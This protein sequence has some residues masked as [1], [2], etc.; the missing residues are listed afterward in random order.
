MTGE[1]IIGI[2]GNETSA[3]IFCLDSE[4]PKEVMKIS[5]GKFYWKGQEVEDKYEVYERFNEW[6]TKSEKRNQEQ[7]I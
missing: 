6:L 5:K 4:T 7:T 3:F 2:S 1:P